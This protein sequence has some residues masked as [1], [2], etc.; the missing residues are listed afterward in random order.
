MRMNRIGTL[1]LAMG[2][3]GAL[4][5]G[6][7]SPAFAHH[8]F[9]MFDETT[10]VRLEGTVK[11]FDWMNPHSRLVL[12]VNRFPNQFEEWEIELPSTGVL[13]RQGW[14]PDYIKSGNKIAVRV[15]PMRNGEMG[16]RLQSYLCGNNSLCAMGR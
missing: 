15:H 16:G 9:A 10:T 1:A 13:A 6:G 14:R 11:R 4:T 12:E 7:V 5:T 3:F 8:S 2:S